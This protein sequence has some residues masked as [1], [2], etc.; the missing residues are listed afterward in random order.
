[1][2]KTDDESARVERILA[3][4]AELDAGVDAPLPVDLLK[5]EFSLY[6]Y[7]EQYR[8]LAPASKRGP[9][10]ME[11]YLSPGCLYPPQRRAIAVAVGYIVSNGDPRFVEQPVLSEDVSAPTSKKHV[12]PLG[13]RQLAHPVK[14]PLAQL[15]SLPCGMGK[16][17]IILWVCILT[18]RTILIITKT[19]DLAVDFVRFIITDTKIADY[20]PVKLLRS[21]GE[22]SKRHDIPPHHIIN[23]AETSVYAS[24][25]LDFNV[26]IAV[27]DVF[28][29]QSFEK[30]AHKRLKL[31]QKTHQLWWDILA[32]DEFHEL[33]SEQHRETLLEGLEADAALEDCTIDNKST[34][35]T[36]RRYKL[37]YSYMIGMSGTLKRTDGAEQRVRTFAPITY[38]VRAIQLEQLRFLSPSVLRVVICRL[39]DTPEFTWVTQAV[40]RTERAEICPSKYACLDM[41]IG[42]F[43]GFLQMKVMVFGEN[44]H[45]FA[46]VEG[47]FPHALNIY[48]DSHTDGP[49]ADLLRNFKAKVN[50]QQLPL[51]NTTQVCSVGADV[52]DCAVVISLHSNS[53]ANT[54]KQRQ[55]RCTRI[56][57]AT[58]GGRRPSHCYFFDLLSN[59]EY[60]WVSGLKTGSVVNNSNPD[61]RARY[62]RFFDDGMAYKLLVVEDVDLVAKMRAYVKDRGCVYDG[63]RIDGGEAIPLDRV[64]D[65]PLL[66]V[67]PFSND[68]ILYHL[69]QQLFHKAL[70]TKY[71]C[72]TAFDH[73]F[74]FSKLVLARRAGSHANSHNGKLQAYHRAVEAW[75]KARLRA[76]HQ[77]KTLPP[78]PVLPST[79]TRTA[80]AND[81]LP[82]STEPPPF[83]F[84]TFNCFMTTPKKASKT[85]KNKQEPVLLLDALVE[86]FVG[87][88]QPVAVDPKSVWTAMQALRLRVEEQREKWNAERTAWRTH[89][90][91]LIEI[92]A[93]AT[94]DS[95]T[96]PLIEAHCTFLVDEQPPL[97]LET[98]E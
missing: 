91:E 19:Y 52:D 68:A 50:A 76:L 46:P 40:K 96:A 62:Q 39:P 4:V 16:T 31:Q 63:M 14:S 1:M 43:C 60:S 41:L 23:D 26:G 55:G 22:S 25:L 35:S 10:L 88:G 49:R 29:G 73:V 28:L 12:V 8:Q 21:Q 61:M 15:M 5:M 11:G 2:E 48:G 77:R 47:M 74:F 72:D 65:S 27:S 64:V 82:N 54:L 90:L 44:K 97:H 37:R 80:D 70:S 92:A 3:Y 79:S 98:M 32:M 69:V 51:W 85:S 87:A 81:W 30:A 7:V 58:T 86:T 93:E 34:V 9:A 18:S 56:G 33:M 20:A 75:K 66:C 36:R 24:H 57:Q 38:S 95:Q 89:L 59:K 13:S 42:F 94:P 71:C 83:F 6:T 45:V 78:P 53:S 17:A 67:S 84:P